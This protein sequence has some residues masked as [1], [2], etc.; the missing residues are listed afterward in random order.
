[1]AI[2][3]P[4]DFKEFLRLLREHGVR[5]LLVGGY[6]VG[7][8]GYPRTTNDIDIWIECS[9]ENA[10]RVVG[11]LREFGFNTPL[12]SA[13]LFLKDDS[14]VRFGVAPVRIEVITSISGVSFKVCYPS[15]IAATIDGVDI[16]L[17]DLA[18]LKINKK[19]A[20]S[21]RIS[22]I[23]RTCPNDI[24]VV[25]L[26]SRA[27]SSWLPFHISDRSPRARR[28]DSPRLSRTRPLSLH[29]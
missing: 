20:G 17:I 14:I 11:A 26:S 12:L 22:T 8:H 23:W 27:G 6:A 3:L 21:T 19:A 7:Y 16:D 9:S 5:Y 25:L 10:E 28:E 18:H 2:E 13:K 24:A 15:R 4:N 29:Q 1:M